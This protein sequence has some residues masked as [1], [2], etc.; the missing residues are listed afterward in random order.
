MKKVLINLFLPMFFMIMAITIY[1][2][3]PPPPPP[4]GHGSAG[5]QP[6][7]GAPIDGG[8]GILLAMGA[9]Y[10]GRKYYKYRKEKKEED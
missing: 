6:P 2:D 1:A 4:G 7:V 3:N 8:L 10:G 9:L 5:N